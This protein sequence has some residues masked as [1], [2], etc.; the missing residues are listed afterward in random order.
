VKQIT[1]RALRQLPPVL[2]GNLV[3]MWL[4]LSQSIAVGSIVLGIL[5][6]LALAWA[7]VTLRP[8][9]PRLQRPLAAFGLLATV[10]LDIVRSNFAVARIVLGLV[11]G[12]E[13]RAGFLDVPL[14][15]RDPHGLAGLAAI[16]TSTPGTVWADLSPDGK[17]LTLHVLDLRDEAELTLWIKTRYEQ[18]LMRIF[19]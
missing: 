9:R 15:L 13:V 4:L 7:S 1:R 10:V 6:A 12:R 16:I 3:V 2:I 11:R 8:L 18:P 5:L 14:D 19:E 17:R